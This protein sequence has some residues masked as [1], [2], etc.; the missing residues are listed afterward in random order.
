MSLDPSKQHVPGEE[1][2]LPPVHHGTAGSEPT[3]WGLS[4]ASYGG[5]GPEGNRGFDSFD[6]RSQPRRSLLIIVRLI[7][8]SGPNSTRPDPVIRLPRAPVCAPKRR[9]RG[10]ETFYETLTALGTTYWDHLRILAE[11]GFPPS[12]PRPWLAAQVAAVGC[13]PCFHSRIRIRSGQ[14]GGIRLLASRVPLAGAR[15]QSQLPCFIGGGA[16]DYGPFGAM[17]PADGS[18]CKQ[19]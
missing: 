16:Q 9:R 2:K 1:A 11:V 13:A 8:S 4:S 18:Q 6:T 10:Y 3:V 7:A 12:A 17:Q 5:L 19:Q 15:N 14:N